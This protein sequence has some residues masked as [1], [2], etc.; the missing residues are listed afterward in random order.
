MKYRTL[1]IAV[2]TALSALCT[3]RQASAVN[4]L[5]FHGIADNIGAR[6]AAH[7]PWNRGYYHTAWGQPLA[8]V[9]PPTVHTETRWGW[10]VGQTTVTPIYH[11]F[12]RAFPG[13]F[14][15][16][17]FGGAHRPTPRWPSH[18][19][20]FGVYYIRGPW[21]GEKHLHPCYSRLRHARH[22]HG[23]ALS[24]GYGPAGFCPTGYC[25]PGYGLTG[26]GAKH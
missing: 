9:V 24:P 22:P 4:W 14:E 13:D 5:Q 11:R 8:Y 23:A 18:T 6:H 12:G 21:G 25:P 7:L 1:A 20:Q 3:T 17:D 16:G 2:L 19:D 26:H 10:G 15:S